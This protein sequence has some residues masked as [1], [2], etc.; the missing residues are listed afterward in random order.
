[1]A[2]ESTLRD[3]PL[4]PTATHICVDMQ[5]LFGPGT[6]WALAWMPRVLPRVVRLCELS[7]E[8]TIFTRFIPARR[9]GE[10]RG[11]WRRYYRRWASMTLEAVGADMVE[12]M[13]ELARYVPPGETIDKPVYSP[14]W[15]RDLHQRL[16]TRN[17]DA[18]IVSGG[19]TDMCVLATVL[20]AVDLGYRT[21]LVQDA[22]CSSSDESHDSMLE[23]FCNRYGQHVEVG[24]AA[25]VAELWRAGL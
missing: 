19:E 1:V 23:L 13:P 11:T 7:P 21:V 22:V 2:A 5:R 25:D 3:E 12:L 24:T 17:C 8:R 20:G 14:W 15:G 9:P 6:E 18:L 4:P 10:G 16:C